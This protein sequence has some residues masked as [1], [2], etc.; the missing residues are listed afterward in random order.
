MADRR[1]HRLNA[2]GKTSG[3]ETSVLTAS[4]TGAAPASTSAPTH[5]GFDEAPAKLAALRKAPRGPNPF[6]LGERAVE[7]AL[8][9]MNECAQAQRDRFKMMAVK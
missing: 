3:G 9:V 2:A 1:S 6:V 4:S 8:T 7:R 5:P